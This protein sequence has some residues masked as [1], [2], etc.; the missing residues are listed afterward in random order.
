MDL[1]QDAFLGG[2]VRIWQ[3]ERGYRAGVDPV[4][5]A[6]ACPAEAGET[7]LELGCG[8]G[9]A[10]LCL[11][12]RVQ[13]AGLTCIEIQ[14]D[15]AALARRNAVENAVDLGVHDGDLTKP[16]P[17]IRDR[18]FDHVIA[19]P[20]YFRREAGSAAADGT[21]ET[22]LGEVTPLA[23]WLD[24]ARRRLKPK[25][26]LTLIHRP[27]RLTDLCAGLSGFGDIRLLPIAPRDGRE[28][29]LVVIRARKGARGPLRLLAPFIMHDGAE[30]VL[31]GDDYTAMAKSVLRD[32]AALPGF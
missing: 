3:P 31:D 26:W 29:S 19:N 22:A 9:T 6:A 25:G 7:V 1:T 18:N 16:P 10:S 5:L 21:R 15:M 8:V 2:R 27:E 32:A 13:G 14:S 28:A 4:L 12:A 20:P 17:N 23:D 11:A 30:H 24:A